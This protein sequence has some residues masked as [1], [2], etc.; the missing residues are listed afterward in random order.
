MHGNLAVELRGP[1]NQA[2]SHILG[3]PHIPRHTSSIDRKHDLLHL[4]EQAHHPEDLE[5][6]RATWM[7]V[8]QATI[9]TV[10]V[11][12]MLRLHLAEMHM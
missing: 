7:E 4:E 5:S 12:L 2:L 3:Q 10:L 11:E 6:Q 8:T 9:L 1:P